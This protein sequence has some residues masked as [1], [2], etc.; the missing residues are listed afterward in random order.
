[1]TNF[2]NLDTAKQIIKHF[3]PNTKNIRFIDH[4][5]DNLVGLVDDKYAL[6]FPRNESAYYRNQYEQHVLKD[7]EVLNE[8]SIPRIL[9][10]GENPAYTITSFVAGNH[11]SSEEINSFP[12]DKQ[13]K[14]GENV[15]RFAYAMHSLLSVEKALEYRKQYGLD[16]LTEEPWGI[17]FEKVLNLQQFPTSKQDKLAKEY[18]KLWKNLKYTTTTVV[19]HDDLHTENLL[20]MNGELVGVLDFGDTNI[21]YPEQEFR[22]LYR[23]NEEVLK[24]AVETYEHLAGHQLNF[25]AIKIWSITQELAAF[26]ERLITNKTDHPSFL[27]AANNLQ[28]W[29]PNGNWMLLFK[30]KSL[31]HTSKQ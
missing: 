16:K 2:A 9:G 11:I 5:Y 22:Q 6:R 4:G 8:V 3:Y 18:Y 14:I 21:G 23:I 1:M 17:Y 30:G 15:A 12:L 19:V 25:E 24:A 27:R 26:S 20:F 10:S 29:F 31:V 7:I 13:R 28:K